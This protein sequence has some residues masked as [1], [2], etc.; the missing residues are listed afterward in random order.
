MTEKKYVIYGGFDYAVRWEMDQ[1]SIYKG[2]DYF[3]DDDENLIGTTYFG[4]P[5]Y[6]PDRLT[7]EVGGQI[8]IL[9]GS[10]I[11]HTEIEFSL[12]DMGFQ[13]DVDFVWAIAWRGDDKCQRL[14]KHN[15]W[16]DSK[17]N[18]L[19]LQTVLHSE[20]VR[21]RYYIVSRLMDFDKYHTVIELGAA[22]ERVREFL[23]TDVRYIP[24][25]YI[26]YS[27]DTIVADL[28]EQP[29]PD[30]ATNR[31]DTVCLLLSCI[32]YYFDWKGVLAQCARQADQLIISNDDFVR[33]SRE[34]RRT[35]WNRNSVMFNHELILEMQKLGFVLKDAV[36]FRLRVVIMKFER[37]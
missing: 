21:Q 25:D 23:P 11:Y 20:E 8:F 1:D 10:I 30:F 3:V 15:E 6:G 9:I 36:D 18:A 31:K 22:N 19:S 2:I 28:N 32:I 4:K 24:S 14:W 27:D 5:I 34:W 16:N 13:K 33:T 7:E 12:I 37:V 26:R 29:V 35:S 17:N